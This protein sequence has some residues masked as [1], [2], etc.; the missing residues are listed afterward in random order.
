[1]I[2]ILSKWELGC[3]EEVERKRHGRGG[4]TPGRDNQRQQDGT[5]HRG[6]RGQGAG[7]ETMNVY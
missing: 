2:T 4:G 1:M 6:G 5:G 7:T 3:G